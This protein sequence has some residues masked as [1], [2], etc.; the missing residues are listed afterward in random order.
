MVLQQNSQLITT[1]KLLHQASQD[2]PSI[3]EM[4]V[5]NSHLV[6]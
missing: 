5:M 1:G 3:W 4:K 6:E 2:S